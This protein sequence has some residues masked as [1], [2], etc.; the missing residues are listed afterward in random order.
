MTTS[1]RHQVSKLVRDPL[2]L[3]GAERLRDAVVHTVA[4]GSCSDV[5]TAIA[6]SHSIRVVCA[7]LGVPRKDWGLFS[8]WSDC[9]A[10]PRSLDLLGSYIDVMVADR[11][12]KPADD[13]VSDLIAFEVGGSELTADEMRAIVVTLVTS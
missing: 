8:R 11:C 10:D 12:R 13:L 7:A 1:F 5:L 2:T 6:Q 3:G 4:A 9:S